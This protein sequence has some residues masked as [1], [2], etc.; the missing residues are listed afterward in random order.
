MPSLFDAEC[1]QLLES[2]TEIFS[3]FFEAWKVLENDV[4]PGKSWK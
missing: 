4:G 1:P 2:L 3:S